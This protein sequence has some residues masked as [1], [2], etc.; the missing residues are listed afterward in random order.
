MERGKIGRDNG[1]AIET[2][3]MNAEKELWEK[4]TESVAA[5]AT[6]GEADSVKN[7]AAYG[8]LPLAGALLLLLLFLL[9]VIR[10]REKTAALRD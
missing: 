5:A 6:A 1:Q 7:T 10:R 3:D 4:L 2:F 9:L 8:K